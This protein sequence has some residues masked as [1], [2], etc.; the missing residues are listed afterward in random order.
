MTHTTWDSII[1]G[2]GIAGL[3]AAQMLGRARRRT[4]VIDGG[5][6]RNRFAAHMHGVLGHDNT[7]PLE[8]LD[9]GRA[10]LE[11]YGVEVRS[12]WVTDVT[13]EGPTLRVATSDGE[14]STRSLL[15]ATGITDALPDIPGLAE[16]WGTAVIHCPYCHGWEVRDQRLGV[17]ITTPL[18][19]HLGHMVRQWSDSVTVF[20]QSPDFLDADARAGFAARGTVVVDSPV[21]EIR[22]DGTDISVVVTEDG[23]AY[24]IDALFA[25]G[26]PTPHDHALA[27]LGL[28]RDDTPWGSTLIRREP[29]G[30]TSHP[31]V[32]AAGNVVDPMANVPVSMSAG[33]VAGARINAFLVTED[34]EAA[35]AADFWERRYGPEGTAWSGNVNPTLADAVAGLTPG[36]SLDLGSG[37]GADAI[38]LA[39]AGWEAHGIDISTNAVSRAREA[40]SAAGAAASFAAADLTT[41]R[42]EESYDLV[43]ASFFHSPVSLDRTAILKRASAAVAPGGHLLVITHAS[44]PPWAKP[45]EAHHHIFLS[46]REDADALALDPG[47]WEEVRIGHVEREATGPDG[48]TGAM[49]DG[50]VMFRRR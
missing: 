12:G 18:F 40:A 8:L 32:W 20:A 13:D 34:V 9:K 45:E 26:T 44:A 4:L 35:V 48:E 17:L 1:I 15:L 7:P 23:S 36:R 31:R 14:L 47:E 50:V 2:G 30:A 19:A 24:A 25:G 46:A 16:R 22:G 10:E 21:A 43:T 3:S 6:P 41:W 49:T 28:E 11:R 39:L 37:E 5:E 38:H 33:S 42:P 27:T 29:D